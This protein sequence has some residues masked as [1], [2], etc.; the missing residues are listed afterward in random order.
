MKF[1][2][3]IFLLFAFTANAQLGKEAW[4]WQFSC[5]RSLDFSTATPIEGTSSICPAEGCA[6]ISNRNTGQLLFYTDGTNVWDKNNNQMP[7]GFGLIGG[8]GSSTQAALIVPKP[9]TTNIYYLISSDEEGNFN[10]LN[11][12][13]NY[14]IVDMS[15]HGGLGDVTIKNV[16]LTPPPTA[17][18]LVG[19]RHNNGNDYWII[20]HPFNSNSF[21]AYLVNKNGI[22]LTP[23]ISNCGTIIQSNSVT[24]QTGYLKASPNGKKL[25][26]G[27]MVN[28]LSTLEIYDF[29]NATGIISNVITK[30]Y[31]Q[32]LNSPYGL[33][34]SPDSK[35]LY[36]D[37]FNEAILY[38]Y[39]LSSGIASNI[40]ASQKSLYLNNFQNLLAGLSAIHGIILFLIWYRKIKLIFI[41]RSFRSLNNAMLRL[42]G[43]RP[44]KPYKH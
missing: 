33:S 1:I 26:S 32:I 21:N 40:I 35:K 4:H 42:G 19:V 10:S 17:E 8:Q 9:C 22:S 30:N 2:L 6:S 23:I 14:S 43:I 3:H 12:G 11:Q 31:S 36:V 34:F 13:I 37:F 27:F 39:D 18:Y 25:A 16:S 41:K 24:A 28:N 29:D 38:Q 7:N 5:N 44:A 15:L 20:T